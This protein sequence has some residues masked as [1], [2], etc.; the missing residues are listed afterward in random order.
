VTTTVAFP[1]PQYQKVKVIQEATSSVF[2]GG[3]L[4]LFVPG[5]FDGF[6]VSASAVASRI[7][8]VS[9]TPLAVYV[10][11]LCGAPTGN[12]GL[13]AGGDN[14]RIEGGIHVNGHLEIKNPGFVSVGRAT[15]YRPPP[16]GGSPS[17]PTQGSGCKTLDKD[18]SK[19]CTGCSSGAVTNPEHG[20]YRDWAT[21]YH[22][23]AIV[24]SMVPACT[25]TINGDVT[26]SASFSDTRVYC[27]PADKKFTL[28]GNTSG[29]LTVI[30]GTIEVGGS[31]T[32]TPAS[33][34]HPVLF[35]ATGASTSEKI[36]LNPSGAY[37]WNG[38]IIARK[39]GIKI[40]A[41]SVTSPLNGLL[42]AE[43]IEVNGPNFRMLGTFPDSSAGNQFGAVVLDE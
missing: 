15:I 4:N 10:H 33:N 2:F 41:S 24:K 9:G 26:V 40:N 22:T 25:H 43:W 11:E 6:D 12:K 19:Y 13:I 8:T 3:I 36:V 42:E 1:A 16:Q 17:G 38:Y 32:L 27:L 20:P 23:E 35:Y 28:A 29:R 37:N 31:G 30:A 39:A 18:D 21:P 7:S 5:A 14:M 34:D